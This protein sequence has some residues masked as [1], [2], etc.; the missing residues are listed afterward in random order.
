MFF[1]IGDTPNPR[2]FVPWVSYA[3]IAVNVAVYMVVSLPLSVQG[4]DISDPTVIEYV[5]ALRPS[6]P[7]DVSMRQ[8]LSHISAYDLY[9][10]AHGY[11][12]GAPEMLDLL[13]SMFLHG[14]FLH[15]AGNM[16]FLWIYGD[17]VE[18]HLG[19]VLYLLAYAGTGIVATLTFALF[20][21]DSMVPLVGASGAISGVLG[22]YFL[23]FPRNR[24]KV[25]MAFFP[26]FFDVVL[27][28]AR[29]VLGFFVI[30]DNLLPFLVQSRSPVA[31]GAHLG[32]FAAGLLVAYA[33]ERLAW[34]WPWTDRLRM[35][36]APDRRGAPEGDAGRVIEAIRAAI[37]SG[38]SR[39]AIAR[40]SGLGAEEL[41]GLSPGECVVL[42]NWLFE[43]GHPIVANQLLRRCLVFHR[44]APKS[45]LARVYLALGLLRIAQG[46]PTAAYQHLLAALEHEPDTETSRRARA[47]LSSIDVYVRRS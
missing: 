22:L 34:R 44:D 3:L 39:D 6:L 2:G 23:L 20:A 15:L 21:G 4:V 30:V 13:A 12:P 27:L 31:Y 36:I 32:G 46:Q 1:P 40:M 24:V 14:G 41:L 18:H 25:F 42:A 8:A 47:A 5:R 45:E 26:F 19:R 33:G 16:L 17:N 10:F 43:A 11:K 28:P 35:R 7:R 37:S 29:L 38:D 9:V